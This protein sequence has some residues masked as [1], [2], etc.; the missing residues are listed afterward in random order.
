MVGKIRGRGWGVQS[1]KTGEGCGFVVG[2]SRGRGW[3]VQSEKTGERGEFVESWS[4]KAREEVVRGQKRQGKGV[5]YV[6]GKHRS[7]PRVNKSAEVLR[8]SPR[9]VVGSSPT[10]NPVARKLL[11]AESKDKERVTT[12]GDEV[13]SEEHDPSLFSDSDVS[14]VDINWNVE[15][16]DFYDDDDHQDSI[17]FMKLNA[18]YSPVIAAV[19]SYG[20]MLASW[21]RLKYPHVVLGALSSSA[22]VLYFDKIIPPNHGYYS[23]VTKDFKETSKSCYETI[24]NSWAEIDRIGAKQNGL[25]ILSDKFKTCVQLEKT[26]DLKDFLASSVYA[27]AA[28]YNIPS[29]SSI[30]KAID[31]GSKKDILAQIYAAVDVYSANYTDCLDIYAAHD[32][33][34]GWG[35]QDMKLVLNKFGSNIIFSNGLRDP[36][37]SAGIL[38]NLSESI[39]AIYTTNGTHC[40]DILA[41]EEDDLE[42]LVHQRTREVEVINGWFKIY[43]EDLKQYLK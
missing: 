7:S 3:G 18:H 21:L 26:S 15:E 40:Q 33:F 5:G 19:G 13:S 20:G 37:S 34:I 1:E 35:W 30:C 25:S 2:K 43:Y 36:Y 42:W 4:E 8:R 6:V 10:E 28:Q 29:V 38:E 23:V 32:Q 24:K 17:D 27:Q 11:S 41:A 22:P 9:L 39:I 31:S 12:K 14:D 16:E